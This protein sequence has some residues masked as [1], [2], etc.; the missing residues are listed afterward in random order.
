[1][2]ESLALV[3]LEEG[4][5]SGPYGRSSALSSEGSFLEPDTDAMGVLEGLCAN[6]SV[7]RVSWPPAPR[8]GSCVVRGTGWVPLVYEEHPSGL[9]HLLRVWGQ[10][11][12][13]VCWGKVGLATMCHV[14]QKGDGQWVG[15]IAPRWLQSCLCLACPQVGVHPPP[16]LLSPDP[17]GS[18]ACTC[19][20]LPAD[21]T[22][23]V[24]VPLL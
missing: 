16:H 12:C 5:H 17:A 11:R 13:P 3:P 1:M 8:G 19:R 22:A 2:I 10:Q 14:G 18:P 15:R 6:T 24:H 4:G 7:S 20:L 23:H 9:G 21:L